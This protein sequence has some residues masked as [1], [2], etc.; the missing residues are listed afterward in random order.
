MTPG[1]GT[2][3]RGRGATGEGGGA[4]V[5]VKGTTRGLSFPNDRST[6][7][8]TGL[9]GV[10]VL[11]RGIKVGA[12]GF[13]LK[14]LDD[15]EVSYTGLEKARKDRTPS[16]QKVHVSRYICHDIYRARYIPFSANRILSIIPLFCARSPHHS[17][18][19]CSPSRRSRLQRC[20]D[21][22]WRLHSSAH[23][24]C[25]SLSRAPSW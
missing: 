15:D 23:L 19:W 8:P 11:M 24:A 7:L 10:V 20:S 25:L 17:L 1:G 14:R 12:P 9:D 22:S 13:S 4:G 2:S 21:L 18:V 16:H 5:V 6:T 3:P